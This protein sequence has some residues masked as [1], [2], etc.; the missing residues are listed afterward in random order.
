[1]NRL[2]RIIGHYGISMGLLTRQA[3]SAEEVPQQAGAHRRAVPGRRRR[4][5]G[6][7]A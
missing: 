4:R 6:A 3:A 5:H 7:R 2:L 1:M